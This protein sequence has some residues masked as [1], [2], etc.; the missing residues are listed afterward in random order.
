M[1]LHLKFFIPITLMIVS[2]PFCSQLGQMLSAMI[3]AD[4]SLPSWITSIE[5]DFSKSDLICVNINEGEIWEEGDDVITLGNQIMESL[6][7]GIDRE[8]LPESKVFSLDTFGPPIYVYDD[9]GNVIG[10]HKELVSICFL[11]SVPVGVHTATIQITSKSGEI[12][13]HSWEFEVQ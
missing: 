6:Q 9:D 4:A 3:S 12:F 10:S 13:K 7:I 2:V 8:L 5:S 1:V 11:V